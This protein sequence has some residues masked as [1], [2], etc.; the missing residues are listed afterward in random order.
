MPTKTKKSKTTRAEQKA[1]L[2][3]SPFELE[4]KL[5]APATDNATLTRN[6]QWTT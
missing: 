4:D 2:K 3:L 5:I 1:L 6:N